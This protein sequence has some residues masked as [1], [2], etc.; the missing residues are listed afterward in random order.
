MNGNVFAALNSAFLTDGLFLHLPRGA[1]AAPIHAIFLRTGAAA[2]MAAYPRNLV[3]L[4]EQAE[5]ALVETYADLTAGAG[6]FNNVVAETAL[7][8]DAKLQRIKVVREH[9]ESFHLATDKVA[10][11]RASAYRSF[12][13]TLS[14]R[15]VRNELKTHLGGEGADASFNGLYTT[16]DSML[17]DNHTEV[18]HAAP[19]CHSWI[20]YKGVLDDKSHA[21]FTGRVY[22][23]QD[24]QKT[25]SN[26]L[27]Q[28]YL[29]SDKATVDTKPQLEIFADDVKCT[30]GAT[31]GQ[32]PEQVVFYFQTRGIDRDTARSMLTYGF[33]EEVIADL[34]LEPVRKRLEA[35]VFDKYRP[36]NRP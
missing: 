33:A 18:E 34:P 24:A 28:N 31:V 15:I 13:I 29:L 30:H 12:T 22:V 16:D 7:N 11:G 36:E 1:A 26:Q 6:Y 32:P 27:N 10:Q 8:P 3:V 25:D 17:V 5:G 9:D 4:D 23:H 20:G 2:R 21:V 35:V 14:G 19:H